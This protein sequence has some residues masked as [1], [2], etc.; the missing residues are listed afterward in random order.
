MKFSAAI[1]TF[2]L[3]YMIRMAHTSP[4]QLYTMN[5]QQRCIHGVRLVGITIFGLICILTGTVQSSGSY[6]RELQI[7]EI[8]TAKTTMIVESH[9]RTLKQDYLHRFNR[10]RADLVVWILTSQVLPDAV[11]QMKAISHEQFRIFKA[12]WREAFKKQRRREAYKTVDPEKLKE[13]HTNPVNWV[14]ACK[15]FLHSRFLICK[16]IIH[17]FETPNA[18]FF[19][20]VSHQTTSPFWKDKQLIL[21]PEYAPNVQI[22]SQGSTGG[23]ELEENAL[24]AAFYSS[25]SEAETDKDEEDEKEDIPMETQV[26][27]FR[28][29][30][31]DVMALF[32]DQVVKGNKKFV[33][34]FIASNKM[35]HTL[36]EEVK[37]HGNKRSMAQTWGRYQHTATMYLR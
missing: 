3:L 1:L 15:S 28:K 9:W 34:R 33:E 22:H 4:L 13:H 25:E 2:I 18:E 29:T 5:V 11:H 35:N 32:E 12:R 26:A 23:K 21:R 19:E 24:E 17:C 10:P 27:E 36:L 37:H 8:P 16:H 31:H 14:C 20:T 30:M 6:G 7:P